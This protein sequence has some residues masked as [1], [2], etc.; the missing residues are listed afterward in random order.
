MGCKR[1]MEDE[2]ERRELRGRG[3]MR[4]IRVKDGCFAKVVV[5]VFLFYT[6]R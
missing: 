3:G 1:E 5:S 4:I 6:D 2:S